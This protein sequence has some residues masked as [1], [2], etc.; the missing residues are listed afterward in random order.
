MCFTHGVAQ[1]LIDD[2]HVF[3]ML[4]PGQLAFDRGLNAVFVH[5]SPG[6]S[7]Y[8]CHDRFVKLGVWYRLRPRSGFMFVFTEVSSI[9]YQTPGFTLHG[10]PTSD[11]RDE[12]RRP[13]H[14]NRQL[15]QKRDTLAKAAAWFARSDAVLTTRTIQHCTDPSSAEY[16]LCVVRE[17]L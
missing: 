16:C 15:R 2:V 6:L 12:L 1:Q 17:Y 10:R 5:L 9:N 13:R 4:E 8:D 3:G 14:E 11:E 7:N